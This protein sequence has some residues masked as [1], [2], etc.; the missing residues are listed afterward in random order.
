MPG[1]Q[2][3]RRLSIAGAAASSPRP[4]EWRNDHGPECTCLECVVRRIRD[5]RVAALKAGR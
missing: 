3:V 5:Q 1:R 4:L 2:R